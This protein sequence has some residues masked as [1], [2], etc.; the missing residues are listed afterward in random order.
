ML[1]W[2]AH[3]QF[4]S[5]GGPADPVALARRLA[6]VQ[7]QVAASAATALRIRGASPPGPALA[8]GTLLKTWAMRGTLHLLERERA[9]AFLALCATVR[10][11][12]KPS[13]TR[14]FGATPAELEALA[15]AAREALAGG[16]VLTREELVAEITGR[17]GSAHLS[18]AL[19]SGWGALLKP[20]A[21]WGVLCHGPARGSLV[22][23][24]APRLGDPP[25]VAEAARTVIGEYLG[26][27][28]PATPEMFD[29]WLTR[30]S[31]RKGELR[32]WFAAAADGLAEVSVDGVPMRM[33]AGQVASLLDGPPAPKVV[34]LG[35][36]D[37]YVLGAGTSCAALIPPERRAEV[38]R[39][40]GWIAPVVLHEG[41]VA[42]T[43]DPQTKETSLWEPVPSPALRE[44][45]RAWPAEP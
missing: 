16:A 9:A 40:A 20:L 31:S 29:A 4:L 26:A 32:A 24:T 43:W 34:L 10:T 23:F 12:E 2:R 7:A 13:W 37:P 38:S 22:T 27:H 21:W 3:R 17:T 25:P 41:R 1:A 14:T 39:T 44:A 11:W 33:P 36:F 45:L 8:A 19:R 28:G 5:G 15:E 18:E 35:A 42:G 6:G 30:G